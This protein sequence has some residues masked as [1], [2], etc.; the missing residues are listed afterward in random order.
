MADPRRSWPP[1]LRRALREALATLGCDAVPDGLQIRYRTIG[2]N[3]AIEI[4]HDPT[5]TERMTACNV[6]ERFDGSVDAIG[7]VI[8]VA[9]QHAR[10]MIR[11]EAR[12]AAINAGGHNHRNPPRHML[13]ASPLTALIASLVGA[14]SA[15]VEGDVCVIDG[16][17]EINHVVVTTPKG[18][19]HV[20]SP[21]TT[22]IEIPGKWPETLALGMTGRTLD[23]IVQ[24]PRSGDTRLDE[25]V[26]ATRILRGQI[27]EVGSLVVYLEK[28]EVVGLA[29][30]PNGDDAWKK[31]EPIPWA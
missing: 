27:S 31:L 13:E 30:A 6:V 23:E 16:I 18:M 26:A 9:V 25:A 14:G 8:E 2:D 29:A 24:M 15:G 28:A 11:R 7:R 12:L 17:L 1:R 3:P 19:I 21:G 5:P 4:R 10:S 20:I 22:R